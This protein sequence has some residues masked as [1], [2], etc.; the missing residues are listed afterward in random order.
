MSKRKGPDPQNVREYFRTP[1]YAIRPIVRQFL[2][3]GIPLD[4]V[5]DPCAGDGVIRDVVEDM[6]P[7]VSTWAADIEPLHPSV[8]REDYLSPARVLCNHYE[9]TIMN[10]PFSLAIPFVERARTES[11]T[12]AALLRLNWLE[13]IKRFAW[14]SAN[15]PDVY[16]LSKRPSF[17][18]RGKTDACAYAWFV[19]G[20]GRGGRWKPL[21]HVPEPKEPPPC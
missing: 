21:E 19:W 3:D 7:N 11:T 18:P 12:V 10:P 14:L 5:C 16:V 1:E 13:G 6:V 8:M 20:P 17:H 2:A 15:L 9:L 4:N